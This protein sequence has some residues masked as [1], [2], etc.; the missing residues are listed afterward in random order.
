MP[1]DTSFD[2]LVGGAGPA[3]MAAACAAAE[4]GARV[5]VIDDNPAAG[6]QIWRNEANPAI[7]RFLR[8]GAVFLPGT[9]IVDA[10][11]LGA[12]VAVSGGVRLTLPY[13]SL[14]VATGAR[15]LWLPFP[16]WTLPN[17]MGAGGLQA[18]VKG[19]L[20]ISGK[21][22]VV[23]GSGPLLLAVTAYLKRKGAHPL[24]IAEQSS[25]AKLASFGKTLLAH[26]AKLRQAAAL[27]W[28]LRGVEYATSCWPTK[29]NGEN[30]LTSVTF[31]H[32]GRIRELSCDYLACGF[33]LVPNSE[34]AELLSATM[35]D[36]FQQTSLPGILCAGEAAGV[37]GSELAEVQ[38]RIAGYAAAGDHARARQYFELRRRAQSF[39]DALN[40]CFSLREELKTLP[41]EHTIVCRCEDV[42]WGR[43][44][45]HSNWRAAK[46]QTRCGMGPCQGRVCGPALE[47]LTGCG[48]TSVRPPLYPVPASQL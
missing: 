44:Q 37:G 22:V 33:G 11:R 1:T 15:E 35:T 10:P 21:R 26:P 23:C 13:K 43:L 40:R 47:F 27:R 14:V 16:G 28:Q 30:V 39:A 45:S 6:G 25:S 9:T 34:L 4:C 41:T 12:V 3:G 38:G 36:E 46:L 42:T 7:E 18:L 32:N 19:G 17:V 5:G 20:P 2:V 31:N 29:A 48:R 24:L 8:S